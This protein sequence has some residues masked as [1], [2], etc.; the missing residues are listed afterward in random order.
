MTGCCYE[1][2]NRYKLS[3]M[4]DGKRAAREHDAPGNWQPTGQELEALPEIWRV[5]VRM[6]HPHHREVK[7]GGRRGEGCHERP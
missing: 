7:I 1:R 6:A 4:P 5:Q 3:A 2:E